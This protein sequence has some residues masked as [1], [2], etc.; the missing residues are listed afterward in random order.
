MTARPVHTYKEIVRFEDVDR[1]GIVY[2]PNYLSYLERARSQSLIDQG[3]SFSRML[4]EGFG[5]VVASVDMKYVRPLK[6][7]DQFFVVSQVDQVSRSLFHM[8]QAITTDVQDCART[9]VR[10]EFRLMKNL[11]FYAHLRLCVISLE[12]GR[13]ISPPAWLESLL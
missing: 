5:I 1:G 13:P 3:H 4:S 8:T 12:T 7:E 10:D 6:L 9:S 2:H 11:S